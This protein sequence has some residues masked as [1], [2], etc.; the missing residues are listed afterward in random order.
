MPAAPVDEAL[1]YLRELEGS[2]DRWHPAFAVPLGGDLYRIARLTTD[3]PLEFNAGDGVRC[4]MRT[5]PDGTDALFAVE[6][7]EA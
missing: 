7:A 3:R 2:P 6:R 5:F 4:E 1:I